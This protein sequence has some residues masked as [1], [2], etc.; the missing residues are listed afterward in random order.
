[1]R[2]VKN[3]SFLKDSSLLDPKE[4]RVLSCSD[5]CIPASVCFAYWQS[6][7][8]L[9]RLNHSAAIG[10]CKQQSCRRTTHS[11]AYCLHLDLRLSCQ[12]PA[13]EQR[14]PALS[15][16]S[17]LLQPLPG[18]RVYGHRPG[19]RPQQGVQSLSPGNNAS[20]ASDLLRVS[21]LS[22]ASYGT[23][24]HFRLESHTPSSALTS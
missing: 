21:S 15:L 9:L 4:R 10:R 7:T 13:K 8:A 11:I 23:L 24:E 19:C 12:A 14:R 22:H 20:E 1:M 2:F 16:P 18:V 5:I 17:V 6:S 3:A